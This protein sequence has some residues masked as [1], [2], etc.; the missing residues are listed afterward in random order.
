M[1]HFIIKK[2]SALQNSSQ[3]SEASH[4]CILR[5]A[6][7]SCP[8][9]SEYKIIWDKGKEAAWQYFFPLLLQKAMVK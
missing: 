2:V 3:L 7:H 1:L 5:P 9:Y 6:L 8:I 4:R